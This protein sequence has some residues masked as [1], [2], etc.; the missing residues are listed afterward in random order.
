M[1]GLI[2]FNRLS[3]K[4]LSMAG[5]QPMTA[6]EGK[7]ILAFNGEI[8]NDIE[9]RKELESKGYAFGSTTDTEVVLNLYLE[10]GYEGMIKRLNGMFAIIIVDLRCGN[11]FYGTRPLWYKAII[12]CFLQRTYSICIRIEEYYSV[13]GF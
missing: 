9:L 7:V 3:I 12:L 1:D 8:Y 6:I 13:S 11:I 2:G 10:L 4:D 5:H